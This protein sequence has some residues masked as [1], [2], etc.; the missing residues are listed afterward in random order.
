MPVTLRPDEVRQTIARYMLADGEHLVIDLAGSHGPYIRDARTGQEYLDFYA[1]FASQPV[2]HNHPRLTDPA[3]RQ[4]LAEVAIHKPAN[5]DVYSTYMA[6]FVET[7]A[8]VARP[9]DMPYLFFID[10]GGLAVEN[11]LKTAFDWKVRKNLA[12]RQ[13]RKREPGDPPSRGFSRPHR[14]HP[15]TYQHGTRGNICIFPSSPGRG[16]SIPSCVSR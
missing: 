10:G 2:G 16:S 15:V 8:R 13:G 11:A 5:S 1:Y 14:L 4:K 6:E 12:G 3:F 9:A 7:F